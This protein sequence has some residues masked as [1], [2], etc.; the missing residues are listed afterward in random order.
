MVGPV[1]PEYFEGDGCSFSPDL[2]FRE[3]CRIHD[4]EYKQLRHLDP[5][6]NEWRK[7]RIK[8]DENLKENIRILSTYMLDSEGKVVF[9]DHY[10]LYR[11]WGYH[12]SK[13]YYIMVRKFGGFAADG[14][15]TKKKD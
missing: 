6:S 3:A 2:W 5:T 7:G 4:W 11:Y 12:I 10:W 1:P 13:L 8:A 9:R 14:R 15:I